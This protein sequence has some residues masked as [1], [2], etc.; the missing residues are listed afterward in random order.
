MNNVD[1][2]IVGAGPVGLHMG[3]CLAK[4]GVSFKII[5]KKSG[6]TLSS[7]AVGVNPRTL[8]IW[9]TLGFVDEAINRGL[10]V[11]GTALHNDKKL[12]NQFDFDVIKSDYKMTLALPQAQSEQLLLEEL[13]ARGQSVQWSSEFVELEQDDSGV[14]SKYN[15]SEGIEEIKSKWIIGCDGYRSA[16]RELS[17]MTRECYDLPLHFLMVDA[18]VNSDAKSSVSMDTVNL[19]FHNH[20]LIFTIPML[21][22]I[23]VVAEI[24][25]DEKYKDL[26]VCEPE[27]FRQLIQERYPEL[28]IGRIDWNSAFYIHECL[29]DNYRKGRVFIAGDAAHT[30]SPMGGQGMNTGLQDT[31]NLAWKLGMVIRNEASDKLL[32]TYNTERRAVG[33]DVLARTSKITSVTTTNNFLLRYL[34]DFGIQH[35]AEIDKVRSRMVNSVA[36]TD[37]CYSDSSLVDYK[38]VAKYEKFTYPEFQ[39]GWTVLTTESEHVEVPAFVNSQRIKDALPGGYKFC[40]VRPDG[41]TAIYTHTVSE[42]NE[43]FKKN[44]IHV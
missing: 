13:V 35:I 43:Y 44:Y 1:V 39:S 30:H 28:T 26:R 41:Y 36:Q 14:T 4:Q 17:G 8:E 23:R 42:L 40:L 12:L 29:A 5:D 15:T 24:S 7:N 27:V 19:L 34:R 33:H 25:S 21:K 22:N 11:Y 18:E 16:V 20:G 9:R 37:I 38:H 3:V 31:W 6:P 10:K 2:L 32:D